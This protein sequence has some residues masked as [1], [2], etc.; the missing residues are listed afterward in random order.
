MLANGGQLVLKL[1]LLFNPLP[2]VLDPGGYGD[3]ETRGGGYTFRSSPPVAD[4]WANRSQEIAE[5]LYA[6]HAI[7]HSGLDTGWGG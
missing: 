3:L 6:A 2:G 4:S 7:C 5:Q 1:P